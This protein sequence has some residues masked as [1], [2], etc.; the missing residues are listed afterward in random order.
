MTGSDG[1]LD[2]RRL[3]RK[4]KLVR[5]AAKIVRVRGRTVSE[6][7][8]EVAIGMAMGK[9]LAVRTAVEKKTIVAVIDRGDSLDEPQSMCPLL[10]SAT[11][12]RE[13]R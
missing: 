3:Y 12:P 13:S 10:K 2:F 9:T 7:L 11:V 6:D 1:D 4:E 8:R 5:I